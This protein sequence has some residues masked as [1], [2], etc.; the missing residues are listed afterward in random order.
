MKWNLIALSNNPYDLL[1]IGESLNNEVSTKRN[2]G[3]CGLCVALM[4]NVSCIV[5]IQVA[6]IWRNTD[7]AAE[8][9]TSC[10]T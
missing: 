6:W 1:I 3:L 10:R 9:R 4:E 8:C 5:T 7:S 2:A